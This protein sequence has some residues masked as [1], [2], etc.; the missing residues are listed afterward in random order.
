MWCEQY[1]FISAVTAPLSD[2]SPN[3]IRVNGA[4]MNSEDFPEIWNCPRGTNMNPPVEK[5]QLW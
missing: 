4:V 2:H 3:A 5:C 1:T